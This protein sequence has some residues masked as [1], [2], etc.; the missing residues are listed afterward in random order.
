MLFYIVCRFAPII[1]DYLHPVGVPVST[2]DVTR[3]RYMIGELE[4]VTTY[5]QT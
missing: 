4:F 3:T 2:P 5:I 1:T